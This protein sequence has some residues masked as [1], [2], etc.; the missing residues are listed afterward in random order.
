MWI[1]MCG[2]TPD[3][4]IYSMFLRNPLRGFG[5]PGGRNLPIHITLAIA[6]YNSLHDRA[7]RDVGRCPTWWRSELGA[8][9]G[10]KNQPACLSICCC[11]VTNRLDGS[12]WTLSRR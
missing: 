8:Q 5:A 6:F 7:S 4:V 1:C 3:V 11:T 10:C 9:S 2:H 12:R